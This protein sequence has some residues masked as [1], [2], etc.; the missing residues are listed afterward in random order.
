M[1]AACRNDGVHNYL[2]IT[3]HPTPGGERTNAI[4]GDVV[5]DG[6]LLKDWGLHR[7]DMNLTMGNLIDIV[8]T[9]GRAYLASQALRLQQAR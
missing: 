4:T 8:R 3:L 5:I 7:I 1:S 9:Q 2:A 6:H